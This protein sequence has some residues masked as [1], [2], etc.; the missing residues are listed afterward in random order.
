MVNIFTRSCFDLQFKL[1]LWLGSFCLVMALFLKDPFQSKLFLKMNG[2]WTVLGHLIVINNAAR[3]GREKSAKR[4]L[5]MWPS[6]NPQEYWTEVRKCP[7][8]WKA[9]GKKFQIFTTEIGTWN[10]SEEKPDISNMCISLIIFSPA[11]SS[12]HILNP[13]SVCINST[14]QKKTRF[15]TLTWSFFGHKNSSQTFVRLKCQIPINSVWPI[16]NQ[17]LSTIFH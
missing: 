7:L 9:R 10:Q 1:P 8:L 6:N 4:K 17:S 16:F 14:T 13:P 5:N 15:L 12:C 3:R 11:A 2:Y